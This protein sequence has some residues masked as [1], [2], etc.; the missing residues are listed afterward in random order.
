MLAFL[1]KHHKFHIL[2]LEIIQCVLTS[3]SSLLLLL[4]LHN[5]A[6]SNTVFTLSFVF[7]F[8]QATHFVVHHEEE[9]DVITGLK[10]KTLYGRPNWENEFKT[11]AGKHPG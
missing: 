6:I 1:A 4:L 7:H 11:I 3:S 5:A 10:Q 9:K 8:P 2:S